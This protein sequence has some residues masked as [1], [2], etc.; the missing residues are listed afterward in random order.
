MVTPLSELPDESPDEPS[1]ELLFVSVDPPSELSPY[2]GAVIHIIVISTATTTQTQRTSHFRA[3]TATAITVGAE[4]GTT[5][6]DVPCA[7]FV[8]AIGS[9]IAAGIGIGGRIIM[10]HPMP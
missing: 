7:Q 10:I 1:F 2:A 3:F 8:S 9:T 6:I 4:A 5:S